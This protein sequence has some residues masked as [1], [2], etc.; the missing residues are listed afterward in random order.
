MIETTR[1]LLLAFALLVGAG[2]AR[3]Q[4][5]IDEWEAVKPPAPPALSRVT[6]EPKTTALLVLDLAEQTCNMKDRPRCVAML[7]RAAQLLAKAREKSWTV[8][9]TLGAAS[10][11]SDVLAP[12]AMKGDEPIFIGPPDKFIGTDLRQA[13]KDRGV[14]TVVIAGAASE[15]AVLHTAATAAF[16][17]FDVVVP[18]DAMASATAYGEQYVAWDL[19]HA[20]RLGD[21]VRL[22]AIGMID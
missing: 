8:I 19:V 13:L 20:P 9:Y 14:K 22:S 15:G 2:P 18:V 11:P 4:G 17:G 16:R 5:V 21:R 12:V 1:R 3:A 10:K 7:P 6:L